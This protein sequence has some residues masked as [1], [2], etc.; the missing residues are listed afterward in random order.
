MINYRFLLLILLLH[1]GLM[2]TSVWCNPNP[3]LHRKGETLLVGKSNTPIRLSGIC[4]ENQVWNTDCVPRTEHTELDYRRTQNMNMN[5]IRF[6]INYNFFFEE[7]AKTYNPAC[8]EWLDEN[9]AYAR[10]H[11]LYLILSMHVPGD[12]YHA[13]GQG[14][15]FWNTPE[16][17]REFRTL[18]KAI[19]QRYR[20]EPTIDGF[21]LLN[22]PIT[23]RSITQWK[24]LAEKT[25]AEIRAI[26]Q[27]HLLIIQRLCGVSQ[28][29]QTY[30]DVNFFLIHDPNVLYMFQYYNPIQYTHQDTE[31]TGFGN[32]GRYP[33]K[34]WLEAPWDI[35]WADKNFN[36]PQLPPGDSD[37][38]VY[39]GDMMQITDPQIITGKPLLVACFNNGTA[40]FDHI[41]VKEFDQK[42][43]FVRTY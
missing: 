40:Y 43:R 16:K 10:Q 27:Q 6:Y 15:S 2:H 3:F 24:S 35:T 31:W 19:A 22:K 9:I 26:D 14:E 1:L 12:S 36:S 21:D 20:H 4:F 34:S 37:W 33:D 25:A 18:W 17:L 38:H 28:Q 30:N 32:G 42:K 29:W 8:W 39:K 11:G 5:V 13:D 41:V 23:T 7:G